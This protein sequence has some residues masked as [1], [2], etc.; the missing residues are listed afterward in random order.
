MLDCKSIDSAAY[1][2]HD[3]NHIHCI[4]KIS[5]IDSVHHLKQNSFQLLRNL[6]RIIFE[7]RKDFCIFFL[8]GLFLKILIDILLLVL[9]IRYITFAMILFYSRFCSKKTYQI[10]RYIKYIYFEKY[11]K[12]FSL[13]FLI[14]Y[15][16]IHSIFQMHPFV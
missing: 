14:Q 16:S 7:Y 11:I 15:F 13:Y 6:Y 5:V 2:Q 12:L 10:D 9:L 8:P 4:S 3:D 1:I